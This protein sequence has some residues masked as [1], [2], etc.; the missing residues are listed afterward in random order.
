MKKVLICVMVCLLVWMLGAAAQAAEVILPEGFPEQAA[1]PFEWEYLA[2]IAGTAAAVLLI[3]QFAKA[4]LDRIWKIPTRWVVYFLCLGIMLVAT[5]FTSGLTLQTA[6][7]AALNA[8]ISALAAY[9][10]YEVTFAKLHK[11]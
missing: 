9:G 11:A 2:S 1:Q 3:V 7:L 6:I 5:H 10:A 4:P 8:F